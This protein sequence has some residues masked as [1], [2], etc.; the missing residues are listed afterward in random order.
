MIPTKIDSMGIS[1]S[2]AP[3][4][5][6]LAYIDTTGTQYID[7][8]ITA[9]ATTEIA[10][11]FNTLTLTRA[12]MLMGA[13]SSDPTCWLSIQMLTSGDNA[14]YLVNNN[15]TSGSV[16]PTALSNTDYLIELKNDNSINING[17]PVTNT[18]ARL[19]T[20]IGLNIYIGARNYSGTAQVNYYNYDSSNRFFYAT[21]NKQGELAGRFVPY[22]LSNGEVGMLNTV[23]NKFHSNQGTGSFIAGPAI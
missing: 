2:S 7:S 10:L 5:T 19:N 16:R 23:T 12:D 18:S 14:F 21:I 11:R 8:E 9:D 22:Q 1:H 6:Y 17:S 20:D 15:A 3:A 13:C 4:G